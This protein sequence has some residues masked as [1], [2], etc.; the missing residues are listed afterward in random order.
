MIPC[1]SPEFRKV[2]SHALTQYLQE[3][4]DGS[5]IIV[6]TLTWTVVSK[7]YEHHTVLTL[8]D[9]F[10]V[11]VNSIELDQWP[12]SFDVSDTNL[13]VSG[14]KKYIQVFTLPELQ[15]RSQIYVDAPLR[16]V[17]FSDDRLFIYRRDP[18]RLEM[19]A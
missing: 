10:G 3:S 16:D 15:M 7:T 11:L 14:G 8:F 17:N 5:S 9:K 12:Y 18:P 19:Y 2:E 4:P 13:Y 1:E 6:V